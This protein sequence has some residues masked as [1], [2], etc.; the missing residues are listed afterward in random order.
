MLNT[1]SCRIIAS[2]FLMCIVLV[3]ALVA[4]ASEDELP[5]TMLVDAS[6]MLSLMSEL[7][8]KDKLPPNV[9][10]ELAN[11]WYQEIEL[12]TLPFKRQAGC[13]LYGDVNQDGRVD[14]RDLFLVL[15]S[16]RSR[17]GW[18]R[19]NPRAD[20]VE[21]CVIDCRDIVAVVHNFRNRCPKETPTPEPTE[22]STNTPTPK[23]TETQTSE[24][25]CTSTEVPT[26]THTQTST[27][28][29]TATQ[30]Q[31]PTH[32]FTPTDTD[33][34][35]ST[36]TAVPTSTGTATN[37][38]TA[39]PT[40]T[41]TVTN[42]HT[43]NPTATDTSEPTS[44]FTPTSTDTATCTWTPTA[45][46]TATSTFT[47][48]NTATF[49]PTNTNSPTPTRTHTLT[50]TSTATPTHTETYTLTFTSTA[51]ATPTETPTE[52]PAGVFRPGDAIIDF[53]VFPDGSTIDGEAIGSTPGEYLDDQFLSVGV[54]F[55]STI[56]AYNYPMYGIGVG[57]LGG[58]GGADDGEPGDNF[59]AG[60]VP[61]LPGRIDNRV[62]WEVQFL[63]PVLR[64]GIQRRGL[65]NYGLADAVTNFYD[66][67]GVILT[68]IVTTEDL[69]FVEHEVQTGDPG[70]S[71][72]EITS[73]APGMPVN[74]GAGGGDNLI[75]S[76][77][78]ARPIPP[79]LEYHP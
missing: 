73:T 23:P 33:L 3:P 64:A 41:N 25:T 52:T 39:T 45:T 12:E 65:V 11:H 75:F 72:I 10:L 70:I 7:P 26:S 21:D 19:Y 24:P 66:A 14:I 13:D 8:E 68:S 9:L 32:T 34:P 61:P 76:Q 55:R 48:T 27:P 17:C 2:F 49:T 59:V 18:R 5:T 37:T 57:V 79:A 51:T 74:A 20:V 29:H 22:A 67:D 38:Q 46:H 42:T 77:V 15:R 71:R 35:T 4:T 31:E 30:T 58:T 1:T 43:P 53:S 69:V 78:G 28:S 36:Q 60:L 56:S 50:F 44:T 16:L 40:E 62:V 63:E 47:K 54:R 6:A